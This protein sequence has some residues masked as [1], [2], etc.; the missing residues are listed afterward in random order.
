MIYDTGSDWLAVEG[1]LCT[2]CEGDKFTETSS[3]SSAKV[4]PSILS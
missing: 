2:S 1:S 4:E 3:T